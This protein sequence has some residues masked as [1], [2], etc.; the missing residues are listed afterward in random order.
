MLA[1]RRGPVD[2]LQYLLEQQ[3]DFDVNTEVDGQVLRG[4]PRGSVG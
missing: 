4:R 3:P 2:T 1:A